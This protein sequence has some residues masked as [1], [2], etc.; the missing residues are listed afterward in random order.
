[1]LTSTNART[2]VEGNNEEARRTRAFK[3]VFYIP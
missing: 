3:V 1:L 2:V